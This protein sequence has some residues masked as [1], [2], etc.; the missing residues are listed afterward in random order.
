MTRLNNHVEGVAP[1][2]QAYAEPATHPP[3]RAWRWLLRLVGQVRRQYLSRFRPDYVAR[4][5]ADRLGTCRH[6]GECCHLTFNCPF[7]TADLRCRSYEKRPRTCRDFP[8]DALDL[9][10]TRIPCGHCY[11]ARQEEEARADSAG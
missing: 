6:C 9:R 4:M 1:P 11:E 10:L 8:I 3:A 5:K 7:L 2:N